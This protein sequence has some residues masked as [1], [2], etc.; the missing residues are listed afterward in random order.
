MRLASETS[1][2]QL[3]RPSSDPDLGVD[4]RGLPSPLRVDERLQLGQHQA[5]VA[6]RL[7]EALDGDLVAG[8]TGALGQVAVAHGDG[9]WGSGGGGGVAGRGEGGL[10]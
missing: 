7:V 2:T 10:L 4:D 1:V 3:L 6:L 5:V 8:L 9:A